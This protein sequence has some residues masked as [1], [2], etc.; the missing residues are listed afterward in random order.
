MGLKNSQHK[1]AVSAGDKVMLA[2]MS[3]I[4]HW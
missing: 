1:N 3:K 2:V 4:D